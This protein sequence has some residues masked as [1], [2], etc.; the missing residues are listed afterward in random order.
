MSCTWT[1]LYVL[2]MN[3]FFLFWIK[4]VVFKYRTE[5]FTCTGWIPLL[6]RN[7]QSNLVFSYCFSIVFFLSYFNLDAV[8]L[9]LDVFSSPLLSVKSLIPTNGKIL[10]DNYLCWVLCGGWST[11]GKIKPKRADLLSLRTEIALPPSI[12]SSWLLKLLF[13]LCETSFHLSSHYSWFIQP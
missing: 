3:D 9:D 10:L 1:S 6:T 5:R 8:I 4:N 11:D 7:Y 12:S 13:L 2:K